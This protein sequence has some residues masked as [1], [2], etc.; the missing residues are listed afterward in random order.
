MLLG[1]QAARLGLRCE[2]CHRN[3]RN[4]PD[5]LFKGLSGPAGTAD[6]TSFILSSHRGDHI[7]N[8]KP[9]PDL[10][11]PKALL[12]IDQNAQN[13]ALEGFIRGLVTEEFDGAPPPP[14]VLRGLAAYVRAQDPA[15]CAGRQEEP[16]TAETDLEDVAA[17]VAAAGEAWRRADRSSAVLMLQAARTR[18]GDIA[19]RSTDPTVHL[20]IEAQSRA[21]GE[22]LQ[23]MR[24]APVASKLEIV[25]RPP[26]I[27]N[28]TNTFYGETRLRAA[29]AH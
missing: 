16:V 8:P 14:A 6:V 1:G 9:I 24:T 27:G 22:A 18:L 25:Y 3:G 11:G 28:V 5:F 17:A 7:D 4:N 13:G 2:S 20:A 23:Q 26:R 10:G 29:L 21:L 12:R 19:E 15:V